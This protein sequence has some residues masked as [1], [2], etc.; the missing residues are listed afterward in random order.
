MNAHSNIQGMDRYRL[1]PLR[2]VR[3]LDERT[4]RNDLAAAVGDARATADDVATAAARVSAAREVLAAARAPRAPAATAQLLTLADRF[5]ARRRQS[6]DD[7]IAAHARARDA[8]AGKLAAID[9]ARGRLT[10]ARADKEVIE[11]H[12]ARWREAQKRL[13]E[14]REE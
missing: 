11:R 7:A 9:G 5:V 8:H 13:A 12:F 14:R 6:L 1:G 3:H 10:A 4:K 2:E